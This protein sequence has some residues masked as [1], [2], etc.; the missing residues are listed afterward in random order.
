[1][2]YV[3]DDES[4]IYKVNCDTLE[5]SIELI[6][7]YENHVY[8]LYGGETWTEDDTWG[9]W[10]YRK[11]EIVDCDSIDNDDE[12]YDLTDYKFNYPQQFCESYYKD[13]E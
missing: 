12:I 11:Y 6:H 1:M 8:D 4:K 13:E 10:E 9:W 3:K 2:I 7:R 5:E